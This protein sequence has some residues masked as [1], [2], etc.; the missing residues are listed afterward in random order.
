MN[1]FSFCRTSKIP[2]VI[3]EYGSDNPSSFFSLRARYFWL[4]CHNFSWIVRFAKK[5]SKTEITTANLTK[6]VILKIIFL[7]KRSSELSNFVQTERKDFL[8]IL[9]WTKIWLLQTIFLREKTR[10]RANFIYF[11]KNCFLK[12][13]S[14]TGWIPRC[15]TFRQAF[16]QSLLYHM[17]TFS[18]NPT[19][20]QA[21]F[22]PNKSEARAFLVT[23]GNFTPSVLAASSSM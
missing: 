14:Y 19:I 15:F 4:Q 17:T 18:C 21:I 23:F 8:L 16:G 2:S 10:N 12:S 9:L 13:F 3:L 5:N 11:D 6:D 22:L 7:S 20:F 1:K